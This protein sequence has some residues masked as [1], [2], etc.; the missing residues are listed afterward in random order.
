MAWLVIWGPIW[1]YTVF[2]LLLTFVSLHEYFTIV[3]PDQRRDR[4]L[5]VSFGVIYA[6]ALLYS[7]DQDW[8]SLQG[9]LV[10]LQFAAYLFSSGPLEQ[11]FHSLSW[12]L[13]G[14]VY[15]GFLVPHAVLLIRSTNGRVWVS[16]V[17]LTIMGG[18]TLAYFVGS[19]FGTRKLAPELSPA[20]TVAGMWGYIIGGCAGG[21]MVAVFFMND[22]NRIEMVCLALL[23]TLLGQFGDLFESWLKR[24]FAVKDSGT[25]LPGHG[26]VLDR[27]D[28]LIFPAVFTTAY[29]RYFHP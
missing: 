29:I 7:D 1:C 28:S 17:L 2:F 18:D 9:L 6:V 5:G 26:G 27:L 22:Q 24:V 25:L 19:R 23:L 8:R 11:R 14:A 21:F 10:V 3:F 16:F 13:L 4:W 15:I 12:S 20:K